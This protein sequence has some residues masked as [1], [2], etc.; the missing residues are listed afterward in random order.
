L[1]RVGEET[2]LITFVFQKQTQKDIEFVAEEPPTKEAG[3]GGDAGEEEEEEEEE[4]PRVSSD[5]DEEQ[6]EDE[7]EDLEDEL[8][9]EL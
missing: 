8:L 2:D 3:V 9:H 5:E 6:A 1:Q 7:G 4:E